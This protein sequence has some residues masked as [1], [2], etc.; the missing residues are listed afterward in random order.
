VFD[1]GILGLNDLIALCQLNRTIAI[2]IGSAEDDFD[3]KRGG[4][5]TIG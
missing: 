5:L 2:S 1:K 4:Q 3:Y